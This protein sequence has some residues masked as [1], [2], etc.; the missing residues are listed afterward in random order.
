MEVESQYKGSEVTKNKVR[1][2]IAA[3][4]GQDEANNYNPKENCFTLNRWNQ[5][6]MRVKKGEKGITSFTFFTYNKNIKG[7]SVEETLPRKITLFYYTQVEP[8][9]AYKF[10][11]KEDNQFVNLD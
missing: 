7:R 5:L 11:D 2:E 8:K 3:R 1:A 9:R 10:A 4:W 6:G